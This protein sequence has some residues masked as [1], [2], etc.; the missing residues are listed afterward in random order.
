M[1][2]IGFKLQK[3]NER[4]GDIISQKHEISLLIIIWIRFLID[5]ATGSYHDALWIVIIFGA[6]DSLASGHNY[7]F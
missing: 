7:T 5:V 2:W 1:I 6:I 3:D 4:I